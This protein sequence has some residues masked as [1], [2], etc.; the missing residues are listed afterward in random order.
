MVTSLGSYISPSKF[1]STVTSWNLVRRV[2]ERQQLA[3]GRWLRLHTSRVYKTNKHETWSRN[4][5]STI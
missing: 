5:V 1:S 4:C 2:D 3:E